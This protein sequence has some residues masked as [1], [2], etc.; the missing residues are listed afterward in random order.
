MKVGDI[1]EC[2][3]P[4]SCGTLEKGKR[5]KVDSVS[6]GGGYFKIGGEEWRNTRFKQVTPEIFKVG[7]RV[8]AL[9]D[10]DDFKFGNEFIVEECSDIGTIKLKGVP[11]DWDNRRFTAASPPK[12][13]FSVGSR[14]RVGNRVM[15]VV[16]DVPVPE[17]AVLFQTECD[18][19]YLTEGGYAI[20]LNRHNRAP[21][22][23]S[24]G[25]NSAGDSSKGRSIGWKWQ[26]DGSIMGMKPEW[27]KSLKITEVLPHLPELP[28]GYQ[29]VDDFPRYRAI[30]YRE[31]CLSKD[32]KGTLY[33]H[34]GGLAYG[35]PIKPVSVDLSSPREVTS[36]DEYDY[37]PEVFKKV[38]D[39]FTGDSK[40]GSPSLPVKEPGSTFKFV[41][42]TSDGKPNGNGDVFMPRTIDVIGSRSGGKS[43]LSQPSNLV[44]MFDSFSIVKKEEQM[45]PQTAINVAKKTA[46]VAF[47]V[48]NFLWLQPAWNMAK[49]LGN[50]ARYTF[51][52]ASLAGAAYAV[53]DREPIVKFIGS[54]LPD[55]TIEAPA[56][57]K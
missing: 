46:S 32:Q 19:A 10:T 44:E 9:M 15:D 21:V 52:V 50:F 45:T 26:K 27:A 57:L 31:F 2:V 18:E 30:N 47:G 34:W 28:S 29:W 12:P 6:T 37:D 48:V 17:E 40:L 39:S 53:Y 4:T 3:E 7:E 14:V 36:E 25:F 43:V 49:P 33:R 16:E 24:P 8:K 42:A 35:F 1:V 41:S 51:C 54:C 13:T 23:L 38:V 55:I 20:S 5:Y 56:I 11:T 22:E